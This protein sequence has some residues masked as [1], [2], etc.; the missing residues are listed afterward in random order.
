ML[1]VELATPTAAKV[2]GKTTWFHPNHCFRAPGP[3]RTTVVLKISIDLRQVGKHPE[4][5]EGQM[6][7]VQRKETPEV[8]RFPPGTSGELFN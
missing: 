8:V 1:G 7:T 5:E 3:G 6:G 2:K 4:E